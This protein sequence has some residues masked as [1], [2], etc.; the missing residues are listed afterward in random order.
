MIN[1]LSVGVT[2]H[3]TQIETL[4]LLNNVN[5]L[6][7]R[8]SYERSELEGSCQGVDHA[9]VES[10]EAFENPTWDFVLIKFN[11]PCTR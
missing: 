6:V 3:L 9:K 8:K 4:D 10:R 11:A 5:V 2:N 1:S 7:D